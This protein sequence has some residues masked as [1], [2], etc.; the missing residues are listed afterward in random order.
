LDLIVVRFHI[1][2]SLSTLIELDHYK[3]F[4]TICKIVKLCFS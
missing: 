1:T 4:L 2:T 3:I